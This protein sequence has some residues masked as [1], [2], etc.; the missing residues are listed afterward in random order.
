MCFRFF[1][2]EKIREDQS[3]IIISDAQQAHKISRV[4]RKKT[5]DKIIILDNFGLEFLCEIKQSTTKLILL[6]I[7]EKKENNNELKFRISLYQSMIKKDKM[8]FVFEKC[9]EMGV[10]EFHPLLSEHSVKLSLK[11]ERM[12]KILK[13][14]SEQS[15]R[16]KIPKL[17]K[18]EKF[19]IAVK[20]CSKEDINIIFYE[21]EK[22]KF[23]IEF[24]IDNREMIR[25]GSRNINLFIGSEGGFSDEEIKMAKD[26]EFNIFSL[27]KRTL[28][29]ETAAIFSSVLIS[30][31][32]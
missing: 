19:K 11:E 22:S 14:A 4:L 21:K 29:A 32:E 13:E 10:S 20:N 2:E 12:K 1:T 23:L 7:I 31:I 5:G 6:R 8:D 15:R 17:F 3:E 25:K 30:S 18:M 28:R 24:L 16:G 26:A 27:G 9:T